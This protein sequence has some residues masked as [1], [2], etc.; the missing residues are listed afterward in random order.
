MYVLSRPL[1]VTVKVLCVFMYTRITYTVAD[2]DIQKEVFQIMGE[3]HLSRQ[4]RPLHSG[5]R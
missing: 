5:L 2:A 1:T 3:A 4:R